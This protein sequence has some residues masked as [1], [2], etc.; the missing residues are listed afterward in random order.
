[1]KRP[2]KKSP[3]DM[4]APLQKVTVVTTKKSLPVRSYVQACTNTPD[5]SKRLI[6][7]FN[8]NQC[9]NHVDLAHRVKAEIEEHG[10][11]YAAARNLRAAFAAH[12]ER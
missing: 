10:L 1:M 8:E 7:E 2:A 5:G 6:C 3:S 4:D 9:R 12:M 11:G